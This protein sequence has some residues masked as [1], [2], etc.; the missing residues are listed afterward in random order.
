MRQGD[1]AHGQVVD[2]HDAG[3]KRSGRLADVHRPVR[4]RQDS[5]EHGRREVPCQACG[6]VVVEEVPERDRQDRAENRRAG[7]AGR[8]ESRLIPDRPNL[9]ITVALGQVLEQHPAGITVLVEVRVTTLGAD[10]VDGSIRV[11]FVSARREIGTYG[12]PFRCSLLQPLV[13]TGSD[14]ILHQV[15]QLVGDDRIGQAGRR[16]QVD[17]VGAQSGRRGDDSVPAVVRDRRG[18]GNRAVGDAD[19]RE[20]VDRDVDLPVAV[21]DRRRVTH[22]AV[23]LRV[24]ALEHTQEVAG[25]LLGD[26]V[27]AG[28]V[29]VVAAVVDHEVVA[30]ERDDRVDRKGVDRRGSRNERGETAREENQRKRSQGRSQTRTPHQGPDRPRAGI[31][32]AAAQ[33]YCR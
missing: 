25:A 12:C 3:R 26:E 20:V 19:V 14:R 13:G 23:E 24:R 28:G 21:V 4:G 32:L 33:S 6:R 30:R 8:A 22:H 2:G 31:P 18:R 16:V 15:E 27:R 9:R 7:C 10:A 11:R 1:I 17:V 29:L 5:G